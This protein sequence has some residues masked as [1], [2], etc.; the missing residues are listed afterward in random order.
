MLLNM[1]L[2]PL[3]VKIQTSAN[4]LESNWALVK[5]NA[6]PIWPRNT[7]P[8]CMSK[9][10]SHQV[11]EDTDRVVHD[12]PRNDARVSHRPCDQQRRQLGLS[13]LGRIPLKSSVHLWQNP[14]N[15]R[16]KDGFFWPESR[17][18]GRRRARL[19]LTVQ[20]NVQCHPPKP[21]P[22][23]ICVSHEESVFG[24]PPWKGHWL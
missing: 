18:K 4:F 2:C 6:C 16:L 15:K 13:Y 5:I 7:V 3:L 17:G 1:N 19:E 24:H 11:P 20:G 14:T 12:N 10:H 23:P 22:K 9:R 21:P 8:G